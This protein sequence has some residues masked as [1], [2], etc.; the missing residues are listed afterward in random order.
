MF[1]QMHVFIRNEYY[2]VIRI[3]KKYIFYSFIIIYDLHSMYILYITR[4]LFTVMFL[5][6]ISCI[7][8]ILIY[9]LLIILK[10]L[11]Y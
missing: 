6:R 3:F 4:V 1:V 10:K 2:F 5:L 7:F 11:L 8:S 9:N